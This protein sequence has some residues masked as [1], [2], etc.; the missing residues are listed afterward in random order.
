MF[1]ST[2]VTGLEADKAALEVTP[3]IVGALLEVD[4]DRK[5]KPQCSQDK[6]MIE[7]RVGQNACFARKKAKPE[8]MHGKTAISKIQQ[9][10]RGPSQNK[11]FA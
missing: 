5:D 8:D 11:S 9:R 6:A 1:L 7:R 3:P 4:L 2:S 10:E